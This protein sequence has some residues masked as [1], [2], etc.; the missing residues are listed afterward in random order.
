MQNPKQVVQLIQGLQEQGIRLSIDD[1]GTGYS[2]LGYLR[3]LPIDTLKIDRSFIA[4]IHRSPQQYGIVEAI[5]RLAAHLDLVVI[6]EGVE[7]E[8]Q[9][10]A[11]NQLGCQFGQGN[12][13]T[14][15]LSTSQFSQYLRTR[16]SGDGEVGR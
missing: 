8:A 5:I 13:F 11:L 10:Q 15:P 12:L 14:P 4:D 1:F 6:A 16:V 7:H 2:S 9:R 3:Q